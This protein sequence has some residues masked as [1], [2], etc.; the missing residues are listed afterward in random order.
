MEDMCCLAVLGRCF[1]TWATLPF[2]WGSEHRDLEV[3]VMA[4]EEHVDVQGGTDEER[5]E[6]PVAGSS[7]VV[8]K[9]GDAGVHS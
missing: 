3:V 8:Q 7:V 6:R 9:G 1:T 2:I 5:G 4:Y